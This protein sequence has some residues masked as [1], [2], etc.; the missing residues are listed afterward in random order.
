[1]TTKYTR[2][3][4]YLLGNFKNNNRKHTLAWYSNLY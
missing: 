3:T 4:F 1:M 2:K